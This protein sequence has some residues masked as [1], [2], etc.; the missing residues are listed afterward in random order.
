MSKYQVG[1]FLQLTP[2]ACKKLQAYRRWG[3]VRKVI[4][5]SRFYKK[6]FSWLVRPR[7]KIQLSG[8]LGKQVVE[9]SERDL[10]KN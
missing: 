6:Y 10:N 2:K 4:E 5:P 7:Y 9:V 3:I 1:E 8:T